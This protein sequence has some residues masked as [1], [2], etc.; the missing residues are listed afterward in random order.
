[1]KIIILWISSF[2]LISL[3]SVSMAAGP[4]SGSMSKRNIQIGLCRADSVTVK[5]KLDSLMGEATVLGSLKW[6]GDPNCTLPSSTTIWLDVTDNSG[7]KGYV[8]VS[9]VIP[10]ANKGYGYNTTGSPNWGKTL[11]S[12]R[13]TKISGCQQSS[14]AKRLWKIGRVSDFRIEVNQKDIKRQSN[15]SNKQRETR[16]NK[17]SSARTLYD[18]KPE[19]KWKIFVGEHR[20]K[21]ILSLRAGGRGNYTS[22]GDTYPLTWSA[23]RKKVRARVFGTMIH[24]NKN[25]PAVIVEMDISRK[26]V[27]GMHNSTMGYK[28]FPIVD[29]FKL[30]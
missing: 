21:T 30:N 11:C 8:R 7:G 12:Y 29:G 2:L 26:K 22:G 6:E 15:S 17:K 1:M 27:S 9:P 25:E 24:L 14:D 3:A 20:Q 4:G 13:G 19:G 18:A 5:W 10:K 16:Y 23:N 28:N